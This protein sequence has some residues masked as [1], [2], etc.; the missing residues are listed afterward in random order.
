M[1]RPLCLVAIAIVARIDA[2]GALGQA[3]AQHPAAEETRPGSDVQHASAGP[4]AAGH[5]FRLRGVVP[6]PLGS[7]RYRP[8]LLQIHPTSGP[9]QP[10]SISDAIFAG[11]EGSDP[12]DRIKLAGV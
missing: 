10:V 9:S 5:H 3:V 12:Q 11:A 6:V 4:D 1:G 7:T 8:Q 2:D